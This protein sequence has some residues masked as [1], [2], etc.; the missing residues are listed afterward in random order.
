MTTPDVDKDRSKV[1]PRITV[2]IP[3]YNRERLV[4]RA[5]DSVAAQSFREF[6]IVVVDDG[7]TDA[8][9]SAIAAWSSLHAIPVIYARQDNAGQHAAHNHGVRLACGELVVMLDSDDLLAP[10]ALRR[11]VEAWDAIPADTRDG[12][13]GVIGHCA[14]WSTKR[15]TG[16][17]YPQPVFDSTY[18]EI[19]QRLRIHGDKPGAWRR[20]LLLQHPYPVFPGERRFRMS[21]A[22]QVMGLTHRVRCIDE[23]LHYVDQ[24][25]DGLSSNTLRK[26]LMAPRSLWFCFRDEANRFTRGYPRRLRMQAH[27]QYVRYALHIGKGLSQQRREI[28]DHALLLQA[29]PAGFVKWLRDVVYRRAGWVKLPARSVSSFP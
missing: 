19:K 26:R 14:W 7:S 25:A 15:N 16:D 6:E 28:D 29:W 13:C 2:L 23:V 27:V 20:D 22:A 5:L 3:S 21:W 4:L 10:E 18:L 8:T 17:A 1:F 12:F 9:E 11:Y 24:Q